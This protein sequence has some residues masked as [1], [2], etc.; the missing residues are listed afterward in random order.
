MKWNR[1]RGWDRM[2]WKAKQME[3]MQRALDKAESRGF[4][5]LAARIRERMSK[6][7]LTSSEIPVIPSVLPSAFGL[8]QGAATVAP[9]GIVPPPQAILPVSAAALSP[10]P[11]MGM[12]GL[13]LDATE[14]WK[15]NVRASKEAEARGHLAQAA[16]A[17][18]R[19]DVAA[20][21]SHTTLAYQAAPWIFP[22]GERR[23]KGGGAWGVGTIALLG[24]GAFV[25]FG[26]RRRR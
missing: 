18:A 23:A 25:L 8:P 12:M 15:L 16:Q 3:R 21:A 1:R 14:A 20:V 24:L 2:R 7:G 17:Q 10:T 4:T 22:K 11:T 9:P 26:G 6:L 19:M 13:G 5:A